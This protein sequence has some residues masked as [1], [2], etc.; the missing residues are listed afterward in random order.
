MLKVPHAKVAQRHTKWFLGLH[1]FLTCLQLSAFTVNRL[2][3][4]PKVASYCNPEPPHPASSWVPLYSSPE[5]H[6]EGEATLAGGAAVAKVGRLNLA[7]KNGGQ[8]LAPPSDHFSPHWRYNVWPSKGPVASS[9]QP[10]FSTPCPDGRHTELGEC[11]RKA[12]MG[13]VSD[14]CAWCRQD[15]PDLSDSC[16]CN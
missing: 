13:M 8:W 4:F 5:R 16:C 10:Q 3:P 1:Q 14:R 9:R 15:V 11:K 7:L 6:V 12:A 2:H